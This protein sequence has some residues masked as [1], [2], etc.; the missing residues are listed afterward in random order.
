MSGILVHAW[1]HVPLSDQ[2]QKD[3]YRGFNILKLNV[4]K[5]CSVGVASYCTVLLA[6]PEE[7]TSIFFFF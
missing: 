3:G 2:P 6:A 7:G 5:S 4:V 1:G